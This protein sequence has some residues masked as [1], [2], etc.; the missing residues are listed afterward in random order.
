[1]A[2][3]TIGQPGTNV[4]SRAVEAANG[5]IGSANLPNMAAR[6]AKVQKTAHKTATPNR[7][8]VRSFVC[9]FGRVAGDDNGWWCGGISGGGVSGG[10][11]PCGMV[12]MACVCVLGGGDNVRVFFLF[13]LICIFW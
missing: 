11:C 8:Q 6:T 2:T 3:T 1:M 13:Y 9:I 12:C 4:H 10:A 7:V 5:E